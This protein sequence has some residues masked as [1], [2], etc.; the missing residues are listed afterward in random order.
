MSTG[1]ETKTCLAAPVY[2]SNRLYGVIELFN[3]QGAEYF[4]ESDKK[5]MEDGLKMLSKALEVRFL[6]AELAK[7]MK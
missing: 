6:L 5:I 3:K 2:I 1:F 7:R 4:Q